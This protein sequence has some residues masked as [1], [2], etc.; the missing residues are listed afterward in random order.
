MIFIMNIAVQ[1]E[2]LMSPTEFSNVS[3]LFM[4]EAVILKSEQ[5]L[6]PGQMIRKKIITLSHH[7]YEY[8]QTMA[9]HQVLP[10]KQAKPYQPDTIRVI[11]PGSAGRI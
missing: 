1:Q 11:A 9:Y 8:K 5:T 3:E 2:F 7:G 10:G 6:Y 4:M